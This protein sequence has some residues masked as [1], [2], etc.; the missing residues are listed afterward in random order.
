[1]LHFE[2]WS[3]ILAFEGDLGSEYVSAIIHSDTNGQMIVNNDSSAECKIEESFECVDKYIGSDFE[4]VPFT[5]EN[6]WVTNVSNDEIGATLMATRYFKKTTLASPNG[7]ELFEE[8][9][10]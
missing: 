5:E 7:W 6:I 4:I 3:A 8:R 9:K 2:D 10:F 1:M